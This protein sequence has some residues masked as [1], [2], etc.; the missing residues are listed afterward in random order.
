M[1]KEES[2]PWPLLAWIIIVLFIPVIG[3]AIVVKLF[4][5]RSLSR[6]F[7]NKHPEKCFLLI[8][9]NNPDFE[10]A[11][12]ETLKS[13][14]GSETVVINV[15]DLNRAENVLERRIY[16]LDFPQRNYLPALFWMGQG[17]GGGISRVGLYYAFYNYQKGK[18]KTLNRVLSYLEQPNRRKE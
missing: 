17:L 10:K 12:N 16:R 1:R 14:I 15:E 4:V 8:N 13:K 11:Y 5:E 6:R 9:I 2:R 7:Q 18:L 3:L